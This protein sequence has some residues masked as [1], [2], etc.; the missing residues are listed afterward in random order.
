MGGPAGH[1][2]GTAGDPA[3]PRAARDSAAWRQPER[4]QR[5]VH[6][7]L[8]AA[9]RDQ[10]GLDRGGPGRG[11][12]SRPSGMRPGVE[13]AQRSASSRM[14]QTSRMASSAADR[15][16]RPGLGHRRRGPGPS[17]RPRAASDRASVHRA[18]V[19]VGRAQD[20]PDPADG[21]GPVHV[22]GD[23]HR[24]AAGAMSRR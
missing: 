4:R 15:L 3:T 21:P 13:L 10:T 6:L 9:L 18:D 5:R 11:S 24:P 12:P 17:G 2:Q 19:H 7:A 22:A 23:E 8:E 20:Q 1:R 14:D 16:R